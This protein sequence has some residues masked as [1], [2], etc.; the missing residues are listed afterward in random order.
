[1][2]SFESR[3][4]HDTVRVTAELA[5]EDEDEGEDEWDSTTGAPEIGS[6]HTC[7]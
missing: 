1:M 2:A 4:R 7:N 3:R 5:G 6:G